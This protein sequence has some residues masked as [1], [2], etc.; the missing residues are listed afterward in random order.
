MNLAE[1]KIGDSA[2]IIK[3]KGRGTFR[4]RLMEMG[5]IKGKTIKVLKQAPLNDP[6]E[7]DIMGYQV[8]LRKSEAMLIEVADTQTY[9]QFYKTP[10][11]E[12]LTIE[13]NKEN[14]F[15]TL[16][17]VI[18]IALVGNPNCGKT[19]FYNYASGSKEHTGNYSGVTVD[20][21]TAKFEYEGYTFNITDLPGTYSLTAYSQEEIYVRKF[22]IEQNPDV[23]INMVDAS[24]LER[25]LYLTTQLI[26]MDQKIVMALNMYDEVEARGDKL[27]YI[28][29]SKMLGIPFVPVIS[30][31]G[32]GFGVLFDTVIRAFEDKSPY[33]RHIH[34]NYGDE[35][36]KSIKNIQDVLFLHNDPSYF[37]RVASR[38]VAIKLLEKDND[39]K[40]FVLKNTMCNGE[41]I[42]QKNLKNNLLEKKEITHED[43]PEQI[44]NTAQKEILRLEENYKNDTETIIADT[45]Y[46]FISGALEETY[47]VGQI[48]SRKLTRQLDNIFLNRWFGVPIFLIIIFLMFETTFA[49]GQYPMDWID[50][51]VGLIGDGVSSILPEGFIKDLIKDAIIGGVGGVIVFLPNIVLLFMF[52]SILE[53]TGYMA[54]V[55]FLMDK[56]MHKIGLHGKS[57]I[58]LVMG[59]GCNVP[60]VMATRTLEN[61]SDR[62]LTM[63][64]N[65]Y[66]SCSARLPVYSVLAGAFFVSNQAT[67]T[68]SVYIV[69]ILVSAITAILLKNTLFKSTE[70]PFVMELPPYRIPTVR[71]I[72]KH[73]WAKSKQYL[74][75]M[76][77]VI[78]IASI[79][80]WA[81]G[82][83][84]LQNENV[85]KEEAMGN[86][87]IGQIGKFIEPAIKPLGFDWK[88]GVSI[89]AGVSAKE[90][91]VSTMGVLYQSQE[92]DTQSLSKRLQE[93][94]KK[95]NSPLCPKT[96]YGFMIFVLIYAPCIATIVTIG[97]ESGRKRW[98]IFS[99]LYS[100]IFAWLIAFMINKC[101]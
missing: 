5:F 91:V 34:V 56:L 62:I 11:Q 18:N 66:M 89:I 61:K 20:A 42:H 94:S 2:V 4:K 23:I 28:S 92:E 88:M 39:I 99:L 51:L 7:Y 3:I 57:F 60:A 98:A 76:G 69:G 100:I 8:S 84:P 1:V 71:S 97:K 72:L 70:A 48:D 55:A 86:S 33:L 54:R 53:D 93:E 30:S 15:E 6:I 25:N 80:I 78:L 67:I 52:I 31:K 59:F 21:K 35:I 58:P 41:H 85:S 64:I 68:F 90:I 19:T 74:R 75:K 10:K 50:S 16:T 49:L 44:I 95:E 63:L 43:C 73:M 37:N 96:A 17:K 9:Q 83:F 22:I 87:Y 32:R 40:E 38:F 27:D 79:I 36:E 65:P 47:K 46:G 24:N 82:Y 13:S 45:R 101:W 81:L 29:L 14:K 12:N 26:D 77:G